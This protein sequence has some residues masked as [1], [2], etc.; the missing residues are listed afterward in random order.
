M[1]NDLCPEGGFGS[2][3]L[4]DW[5]KLVNDYDNG[6]LS[7][8]GAALEELGCQKECTLLLNGKGGTCTYPL[9]V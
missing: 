8:L 4:E 9:K 6:R 2:L 1:D 7:E 3:S 5:G